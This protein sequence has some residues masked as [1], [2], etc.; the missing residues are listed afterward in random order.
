MGKLLGNLLKLLSVAQIL[1]FWVCGSVLKSNDFC[2]V[3]EYHHFHHL[4]KTI[5]EKCIHN[6]GKA[7]GCNPCTSYF[8][9]LFA[10]SKF[11]KFG[12]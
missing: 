1:V 10:A 8:L 9:K 6:E 2:E 4:M 7:S 3:D 12:N 5:Q 11:P